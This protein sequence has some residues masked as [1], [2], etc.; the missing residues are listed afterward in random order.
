M[1]GPYFLHVDTN[2]PK[3]KVN[4]KVLGRDGCGQPSQRTLKLI[5]SPE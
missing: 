1:K 4:Q 3:L 5:V 2:S